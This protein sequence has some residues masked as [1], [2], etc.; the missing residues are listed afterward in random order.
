[1][2]LILEEQLR[3]HEATTSPFADLINSNREQREQLNQEPVVVNPYQNMQLARLQ[4]S[5][6]SLQLGSVESK[7]I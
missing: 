3:A 2:K 1:M 5:Y 6:G 4:H 7:A